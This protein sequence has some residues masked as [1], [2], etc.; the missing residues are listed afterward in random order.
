MLFEST[1][2]SPGTQRAMTQAGLPELT[3]EPADVSRADAIRTRILMEADDVLTRLRSDEILT[4]AQSDTDITSPRQV[5]ED[6]V[7]AAQVA[8]NKIRH[9][10]DAAW[11]IS[12]EESTAEQLLSH[13][14]T[15][16][17]DQP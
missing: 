1:G 4:E 15:H 5:S 10:A 9:Q 13:L 16:P 17:A 3:G 12:H 11:W 2:E 14:M 6:Q 7:H 8:L